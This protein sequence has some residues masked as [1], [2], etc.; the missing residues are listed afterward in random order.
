MSAYEDENLIC[1]I[2]K[3]PYDQSE[4]K[5]TVFACGHSCCA[6]HVNGLQFC[7]SCQV[8]LHQDEGRISS[9]RSRHDAESHQSKE[10]PI[11]SQEWCVNTGGDELSTQ[12]QHYFNALD[13]LSTSF[14][15]VKIH[16]TILDN[17]QSHSNSDENASNCAVVDGFNAPGGL[18]PCALCGTPCTACCARCGKVTYCCRFVLSHTLKSRSIAFLFFVILGNDILSIFLY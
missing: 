12:R 4:H 1:P 9:K 3:F 10:E 8:S 11:C 16:D 15:D 2:C 6:S 7:P 17:K 13:G 14:S 5:A 18:Q